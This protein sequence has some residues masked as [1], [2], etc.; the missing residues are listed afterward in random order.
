M[1]A[2]VGVLAWL[3]LVD[4][5]A[6]PDSVRAPLSELELNGITDIT[7]T[8]SDGAPLTFRR[9][10]DGWR[11][12]APIAFAAD[13]FQIEA[14]LAMLHA[15]AKRLPRRPDEDPGF[16]LRPP[17]AVLEVEGMTLAVGALEPLSRQRYVA[18]ELTLYLIDDAWYRHLFSTPE[19]YLDPR[20]AVRHGLPWR[21]QTPTFEW[22]RIDGRWRRTPRDDARSADDAQALAERWAS[23]RA[24]LVDARDASVPW[25]GEVSLEFEGSSAPLRFRLARRG[26][27]VLLSREAPS[28]QYQL[29][30]A[31]ALRLLSDKPAP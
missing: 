25:S 27:L 7:L 14:L 15:P 26:E 6:E 20:P 17:Q 28:I 8:R 11:M 31:Q 13:D 16:G 29:T 18:L 1:L 24:V 23:V 19:R 3:V 5:R 2:I 9:D 21:I 10:A 4:D 12:L 30:K 22:R